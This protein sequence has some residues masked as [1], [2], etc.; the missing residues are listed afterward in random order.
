MSI[1][2]ITLLQYII[3]EYVC[4]QPGSKSRGTEVPNPNSSESESVPLTDFGKLIINGSSG[5]A[6]MT[7]PADAALLVYAGKVHTIIESIYITLYY[8]ILYYVF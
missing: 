6:E 8:I 4:K 3:D 1:P 7:S 2:I 5:N